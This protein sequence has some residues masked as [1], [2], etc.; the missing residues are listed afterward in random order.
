M[1][2]FKNIVSEIFNLN[3][4]I[5]SFYNSLYNWISFLLYLPIFLFTGYLIE[6]TNKNFWM[7]I[8]W[9]FLLSSLIERFLIW[10]IRHFF[11]GYK[12]KEL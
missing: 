6:N 3:K 12:S 1:K 10:R 7:V 8:V 11:F 9:A 2:G 4:I 5:K